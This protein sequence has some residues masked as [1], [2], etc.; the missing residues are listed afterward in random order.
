MVRHCGLYCNHLLRHR[1]KYWECTFQ[2]RY[3]YHYQDCIR[4]YDP[5]SHN[6]QTRH[7]HLSCLLFHH[8]LS[9][10]QRT[11]HFYNKLLCLNNAF[12]LTNHHS[13]C[14]HH[15]PSNE[16]CIH[17]SPIHNQDL[18]IPASLCNHHQTGNNHI[19]T[20]HL[21]TDI[22]SHPNYHHSSSLH[23]IYM[24]MAHCLLVKVWNLRN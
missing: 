5:G 12:H 4:T 1:S 24:M 9:T 19:R 7:S 13:G 16:A 11:H 17:T 2:M 22:R 21:D 15:I 8:L 10:F 14:R 3:N 18:C 23:C 20:Y 6:T